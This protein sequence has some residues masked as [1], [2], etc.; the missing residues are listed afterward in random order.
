[1]KSAI[2]ELKEA[3]N[4]LISKFSSGEISD[5]V[6][7][8]YTEI[9]DHY[10]RKSLEESK[11]GPTLL[12][13]K[14]PFAFIAVGGYGRM[15]LC[16]HSDLDII[17]L[18]Y[19]GIPSQAKDLI[20]ETIYPLWD[21]GF[22]VGYGIRT[23]KDCITLSK[24]DFEVM[25]SM[26]SARFICG[27]SKL[28]LS[29]M[30]VLE[31][32]V[33]SKKASL[34]GLWLEDKDRYRIETYGDASHLLEPNLKEGIGGLRDYH[35]ILWL[36]KM[37]FDVR[38]SK[39]L[40]Y[41]GIFSDHEYL[42]LT[43][44]VSF[45]SL[46]R[47][48]L[49]QLS[50]RKNDRLSFEYQ[51]KIAARLG[52]QD[53]DGVLAVEQFLGRL[54]ACMSS[55]KSL[56]R[57]FT[58]THIQKRQSNKRELHSK[59]MSEDFHFYRDEIS[60]SSA[61]AILADPLL[62]MNIFEQSSSSG[63]ALSMEAKRL[64]REFLYLV[65]NDFRKSE[66]A[67][68]GFLNIMN[69]PNTFETL[70]QMFETGFLDAF[71]PEF[72][73]IRDR[74]QFDTYHLYPVGRHLLDTVRHLKNLDNQQDILFP[75][76][77]S[78][79]S[80][81][82]SLFLAALFHDIGKVGKDHA[83]KGVDI[84]GNILKRFQYQITRGKD[85]LFLIRHHLLLVETATMR[86]LNDEKTVINCARTI[87]NKE[88]LRMLYLLT[89]ADSK[90]TGPR[91]WNE[92]IANLVQELFFKVLH[93][94]EQGELASSDASRKVKQTRAGVFKET[95]SEWSSQ[96]LE[97]C[98][99]MMPPRYLLNTSPRTIIRHLTLVRKLKERQ[100]HQNSTSFLLDAEE[101]ESSNCWVVTFLAK[102]RPGIFSDIAGVL[103]LHNINILSAD[104]YTWREGTV[105]DIFNVTNPLDTI[106]AD[107]TWKR[108]QR[109][110]K[111]I[112]RGKLYLPYR[113]SQKNVPSLVSAHTKHARPPRVVV[114]NESSDF[115]TVIEVFAED[116]IGLLYQITHTLTNLRLDI[117]VAK[118]ATKGDLI[119]D[120][121]YV[122]DLEGQKVEDEDQVE[123]IRAALRQQL[124][125]AR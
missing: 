60:F 45:I 34:F 15:E 5:S 61:T 83:R 89:W 114:N 121:F 84:A 63:C 50:N 122:R 42:D 124:E 110:L 100:K 98:F 9:I 8:N 111:N 108:I 96:D 115:F 26:L 58:T 74:V 119:A 91:A 59:V 35:H 32:K 82:E 49:H 112:F 106:F 101:N 10:F 109:D 25:T 72:R 125:Q 88:R 13:K 52:F 95:P 77:F 53:H 103:A 113:L 80:N 1:M 70:D 6:Q 44:N 105:V 102:D 23:I 55:I 31:K 24:D 43:N 33:I 69:G 18:F 4:H 90:A 12:R 20:E 48:H 78:D 7:E 27:D 71:I 22:D 99:E 56:N 117:R 39:D 40:E 92:W 85:I 2:D 62:L 104:I 81:P 79:L 86:D 97:Y 51:E 41:K 19:A 3:R 14:N 107:E 65:D 36:G 64:V 28:Y 21:L 66:N 57:S 76:I 17:I 73:R 37:L 116:R 47:N 46:V 123:E 54:H 38:T 29:L 16:L 75:D 67:V 93:I 87:E 11:V 118:I 120:V 68:Q 30:T 94:L